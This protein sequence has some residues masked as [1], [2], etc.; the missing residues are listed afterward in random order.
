MVKIVVFAPHP[1][2]EIFGCGGSILKWIE[3]GHD[4]HIIYISDNRAWLEWAIKE[5]ELIENAAT[6]F[7]NFS[8]DE[9]AEI[10]IKEAKT[11]SKALGIPERNAYFFKFHDQE[12]ANNISVG[13]SLSK[14]IVKDANRIVLPCNGENHVDHQATHVIAKS[15]AR[16]LALKAEFY[17]YASYCILTAPREKQIK[18]DVTKYRDKK[19]EVMEHYKTQLCMEP[20]LIAWENFKVKRF[21]RFGVFSFEDMNKYDNF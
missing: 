13:V 2:D 5:N 1:D 17:A 18:I 9:M 15:A 14:K 4:V 12:V 10:C 16:E 21:E 7:L 6:E 3:E 20:M 19:Y 8:G 11:A